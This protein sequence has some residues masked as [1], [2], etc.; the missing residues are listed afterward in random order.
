MNVGHMELYDN[1]KLE[2]NNNERIRKGEISSAIQ[3]R[4]RVSKFDDFLH[5]VRLPR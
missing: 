2:V 3:S 4:K 1:W 5:I